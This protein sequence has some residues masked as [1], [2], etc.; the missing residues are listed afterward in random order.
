MKNFDKL[1]S[2]ILESVGG[3]MV[4]GGAG[5]T[6]G[7]PSIPIGDTGGSFGNVDSYNTGS[8]VLAKPLGKVQR[9]NKPEMINSKNRKRR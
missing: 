9:R 5:S 8:S 3:A 1:V 2:N 6:L 7:S 4:A